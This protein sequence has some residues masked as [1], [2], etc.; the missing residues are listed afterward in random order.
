MTADVGETVYVACH[1]IYEVELEATYFWYKQRVGEIPK[2]IDIPACEGKYCNFSSKKGSNKNEL[3][4]E[5]RKVQVNDSGSYYCAD[6]DGYAPLQNAP[7]LLVGDSSTNKTALLVLVPPIELNLTESVPLVCLVSGVSS[8]QI[9]VFWNISGLV[10]ESLSDPGTMEADGTYS[11]RN[12]IMVSTETWTNGSICT[13]VAQL[14]PEGKTLGKSVSFAKGTGTWTAWCSLP[15]PVGIPVLVILVLLV[16]LISIWH[17]K[18]GRSEGRVKECHNE[19][20]SLKMRT[21]RGVPN[22]RQTGD[23]RQTGATRETQEDTL[24]PGGPLYASL[25][26]VNLEKRSQKKAGRK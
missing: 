2:L 22:K 12:H 4:L 5:L 24:S 8:R 6:K 3:I 15:V 9:V 19:S 18:S 10:T 17:C 23:H 11:I 16:I 26:L 1:H 14:G 25:D 13:C 7:T 21:E 20:F